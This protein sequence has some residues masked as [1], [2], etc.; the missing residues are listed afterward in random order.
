MDHP[1]FRLV[2]FPDALSLLVVATVH[3]VHAA[4][5]AR[6]VGRVERVRAGLL[7]I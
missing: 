5:D 6:G 1:F 2:P 7:G 3:G 4:D